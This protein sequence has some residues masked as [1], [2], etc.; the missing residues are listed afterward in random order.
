[1]IADASAPLTPREQRRRAIFL[2]V[3]A[4]TSAGLGWA[5]LRGYTTF[6]S[7]ATLPALLALLLC[8]GALLFW[9]G[10]PRPDLPPGPERTRRGRFVLLFLGVAILL[11]A[12]RTLVG[13]P[14]LF[15]LPAIAVLALALIRPPA[16][17]G[18]VAYALVLAVVA[19]IA[20]LG[21]QWVTI[22]L[23]A[24]AALQVA[25]VFPGLL[26]GW[27]ILRRTGLLDAGLG[28]TLWPT[29]GAGPAARAFALGMLNALPW[30]LG[31]IV[32]GSASGESW[33]QHWWQPLA[34]IQPAIA[35]E[36]WGRVLLVPLL[37]LAFRR[38]ATPRTALTASVVL[39]VYWFAYLHTP[40]GIGAL[41]STLMIG[42]LYA[43]P[44]SYLWLRRGLER[45]VGFHFALD[46]LKFVV[47][48][49]MNGG[50]WPN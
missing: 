43:L 30:G 46:L 7:Q 1:M 38:V 32:L 23:W 8:T 50:Y 40:G 37:F 19:G 18:E 14:L 6:D 24:W 3:W 11:F 25:I 31:M 39:M 20:G 10:S 42:T 44:T 49:L 33:V 4:L 2:V 13:P 17:R 16:G 36:A 15:A 26:A 29:E 28:R 21:A 45:A 34:A 47:A 41:I 35:E 48:Y 27:A 9:L 22:P 12:L 5:V